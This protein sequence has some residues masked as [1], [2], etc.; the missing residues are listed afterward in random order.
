M[1][2]KILGFSLVTIGLSTVLTGC[3]GV[4]PEDKNEVDVTLTPFTSITIP[5]GTASANY[6]LTYSVKANITLTSVTAT[7][8]SL[9]TKP[10]TGVTTSVTGSIAGKK[11][12]SSTDYGITISCASTAYNQKYLLTLTAVAGSATTSKT[13]TFSL[14]G[15]KD[16]GSVEIPTI[17]EKTV[18]LGANQVTEPSLLDA[19]SMKAYSNTITN[20]TDRAKIDLIFSYSTILQP[21][22]LAF[23]SPGVAAGA[24]YSNWLNKASTQFKV[25]TTTW[26]SIT[27]QAQIDALWGA[28]AGLERITVSEG[29]IIIV[30]TSENKY[31]LIQA[32]SIS[33]A[34]AE[35]VLNIKGKY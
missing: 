9:G 6:P 17:L 11:D 21:A 29:S 8:T 12:V 35:A 26:A 15:G 23:T 13:D 24:P 28:G 16:T 25:V 19:D 5:A 7:V 3:F 31:K 27:T 32:V 2:K 22:A 30:K 14:I 18:I 20:E 1:I 33:G 4:D 34:A 10:A